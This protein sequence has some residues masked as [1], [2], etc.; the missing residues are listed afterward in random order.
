MAP[1][2]IGELPL[3]HARC[4][5]NILVQAHRQFCT[6][7]GSCESCGEQLNNLTPGFGVFE[8]AG[9]RQTLCLP[10][11]KVTGG[12]EILRARSVQ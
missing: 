9:V 6:P 1:Q 8:N 3:G 12:E 7:D 5:L 11:G 4:V 2:D 10:C